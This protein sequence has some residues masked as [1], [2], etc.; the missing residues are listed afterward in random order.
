[1]EEEVCGRRAEHIQTVRKGMG[2]T[3]ESC[4]ESED[5]PIPA[6]HHG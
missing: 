3:C 1:M 5:T 4:C 2:V 6:M